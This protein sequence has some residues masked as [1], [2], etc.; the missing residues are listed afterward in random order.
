MDFNNA[1]PEPVQHM[2]ADITISFDDAIR[3]GKHRI[4]LQ[5]NSGTGRSVGTE[6]LTVN[7]PPGVRD[8]GRLRIPGKGG[9]RAAGRNGDLMLRI[10]V[11]PHRF[12]KREGNHLHLDL[13][14]TVS[15]AVL[16]TRVDVP[17]LD[18]RATLKIPP[19]TQSGAVLRMKGKGVPDPKGGVRGDMLVHI[20]VT[21][22]ENPDPK[23][24]KLFEDLKH[25]EAD[26]RKDRF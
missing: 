14:V 8:G 21:V 24:K 22:P 6:T 7:I 11:K 12:F 10:H 23:A 18:G 1:G 4:S 16:G 2:E 9:R 26:P 17:T 3:G 13:P 25:F 20:Q 15:E 19:V 5:H